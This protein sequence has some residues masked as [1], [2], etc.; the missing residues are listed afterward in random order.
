MRTNE[1]EELCKNV[2]NAVE[3]LRTGFRSKIDTP[4]MLD[5]FWCVQDHLARLVDSASD[6]QQDTFDIL[7][8][9][10]PRLIRNIIDVLSFTDRGQLRSLSAV[11]RAT[12]AINGSLAALEYLREEGRAM[13]ATT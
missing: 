8:R 5:R 6:Y 9:N 13:A 11:N 4:E 12:L 3:Q 10:H 7:R 1:M 2:E